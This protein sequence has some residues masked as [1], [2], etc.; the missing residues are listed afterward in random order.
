MVFTPC[1]PETPTRSNSFLKLQRAASSF[2]SATGWDNFSPAGEDDDVAHRLQ[3]ALGSPSKVTQTSFSPVCSRDDLEN[4]SFRDEANLVNSAA[5]ESISCFVAC[6]SPPPR[7]AAPR[8]SLPELTT[9]AAALPHLPQLKSLHSCRS[10]GAHHA[11]QTGSRSYGE[12][13]RGASS[14]PLP[15]ACASDWLGAALAADM[16]EAPQRASPQPCGGGIAADSSPLSDRRW[17]Q[18]EDMCAGTGAGPTPPACEVV[19]GAQVQAR[20]PSRLH[21]T[22]R[23]VRDMDHMVEMA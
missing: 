22:R 3:A 10:A 12:D 4:R 5:A 9:A 17:L 14:R 15:G 16:S 21:R 7:R 20:T 18:Q 13:A 23:V 8:S 1:P 19:G 2:S 11:P 6:W